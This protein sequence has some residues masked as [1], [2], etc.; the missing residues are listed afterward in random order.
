MG[1]KIKLAAQMRNK[2]EK[3]NVLRKRG[4]IPAVMYGAKTEA[5]SI[6]VEEKVFAKVYETAGEST[7]VNLSVDGKPGVNTLIYDVQKD[8]AKNRVIH[9]DFL[10]VDM[11]EKITTNIPLIFIGES[12]AVEEMQ[13]SLMKNM[14]EIEVE[15]LPGDL[16]G[17]IEVDISVLED[18]DRMITV[19]DIKLPPDVKPTAE[20]DQLVASVTRLAVEEEPAA[21][22]EEAAA[23]L[24]KP[25]EEGGGQTQ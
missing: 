18:F 5:A 11:K 20:P 4:M 14:D 10:K 12:K 16:V 8:P 3:T 22:P 23:E 7:L 17:Q 24:E 19:A 15:C 9:V 2:G 21:A 25:A 6:A 13:G 1:E